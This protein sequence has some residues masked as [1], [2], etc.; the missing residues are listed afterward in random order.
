MCSQAY[1]P[2]SA[3]FT[4]FLGDVASYTGVVTV[5]LM[6]LAPSMFKLLGWRRTARATPNFL[7]YA[8]GPFFLLGTTYQAITHYRLLLGVAGP[9][10]LGLT[11]RTADPPALG[12]A[13]VC[14]GMPHSRR[15]QCGGE[16]L[17]VHSDACQFEQI[18][19]SSSPSGVP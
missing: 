18:L 17:S 7:L 5:G 2:D 11:V 16:T 4:A 6:L 3:S 14:G 8:G 1:C 19:R 12:S 15:L 9:L 13:L 10:L